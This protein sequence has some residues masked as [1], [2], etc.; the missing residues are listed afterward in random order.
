MLTYQCHQGRA[1]APSFPQVTSLL[2]EGR[3][4]KGHVFLLGADGDG[5]LRMYCLN[6]EEAAMAK[7]IEGAWAEYVRLCMPDDVGESE[8]AELRRTF[9]SGAAFVFAAIHAHIA[10]PTPDDDEEAPDDIGETLDHLHAE[11]VEW[12][13]EGAA[14]LLDAIKESADAE[15]LRLRAR[16]RRP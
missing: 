7:M 12:G 3:L 5:P 16:D 9:F 1:Q 8:R 2:L 4:R 15:M 13:K 14:K 10:D 11:L 6:R